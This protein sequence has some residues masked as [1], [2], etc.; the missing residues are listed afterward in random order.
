MNARLGNIN[1]MIYFIPQATWRDTEV[2][3]SLRLRLWCYI[4]PKPPVRYQQSSKA[5]VVLTTRQDSNLRP[6]HLGRYSNQLS[7]M[8]TTQNNVDGTN[9]V[10]KHSLPLLQAAE[11]DYR[12][13][14]GWV[15]HLSRLLGNLWSMRVSIPHRLLRREESIASMSLI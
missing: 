7:Y 11:A 12:L 10:C 9:N 13:K 8:P 3:T 15:H 2:I 5:F 6:P 14:L 4:T 1:F